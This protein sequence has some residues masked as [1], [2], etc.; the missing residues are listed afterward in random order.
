M[1]QWHRIT[2]SLATYSAYMNIVRGDQK[3][4]RRRKMRHRNPRGGGQK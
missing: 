1:A 4:P 3:H 2:D